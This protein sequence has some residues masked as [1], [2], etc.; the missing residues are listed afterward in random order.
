MNGSTQDMCK[1]L[2]C[3]KNGPRLSLFFYAFLTILTLMSWIA[4]AMETPMRKDIE[5]IQNYSM[6]TINPLTKWPL[7]LYDN[8]FPDAS[9]NYSNHP[10]F[11]RIVAISLNLKRNENYSTWDK[12]QRIILDWLYTL[13]LAQCSALIRPFE[14]W[15]IQDIVIIALRLTR[16][17]SET[18]GLFRTQPQF[19]LLRNITDT[20]K[21]RLQAILA[22]GG[23]QDDDDAAFMNDVVYLFADVI[24]E[25]FDLR[26]LLSNALFCAQQE[27]LQATKIANT[28]ERRLAIIQL[29]I[30]F[31]FEIRRL[32][33]FSKAS[34]RLGRLIMHC[35][36]AQQCIKPITIDQK[37]AFKV[38]L[39]ASFKADSSE[40]LFN[41]LCYIIERAES[42][43]TYFQPIA[44]MESI[45]PK[46]IIQQL[47][48]A[49]Q[50]M[51]PDKNLP[52]V[53]LLPACST[54]NK[55]SIPGKS[56]LVCGRCKNSIYCSKQCQK[57][58]WSQ[59]KKTCRAQ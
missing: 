38:A 30:D 46:L 2:K 15:T 59:H 58:D 34:D 52:S 41:Y 23:P 8:A 16:L 45:D 11:E 40:P 22:L 32:N 29:A 7:Y 6:Y 17:T 27:Y 50:E 55:I 1:N 28:Q 26:T 37:V 12:K 49:L 14:T 25:P 13:K 10:E 43:M 36:F 57:N 24:P 3:A 4:Q 18:P 35:I 51:G 42:F 47:A 56:H 5:E 19:K 21:Q 20:E 53:T 31:Y 39:R 44:S 9:Y 33:P 48:A 54:C